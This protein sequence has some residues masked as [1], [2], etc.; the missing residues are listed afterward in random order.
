MKNLNPKEEDKDKEELLRRLDERQKQSEKNEKL[1]KE[2]EELQ[3]KL[4]EDELFEKAD[5]LKQNQ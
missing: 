5:K 3:K 2:L 1:L 4:Q